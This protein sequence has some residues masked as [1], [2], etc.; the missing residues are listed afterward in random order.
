LPDKPANNTGPRIRREQ[1]T[2]TA[3]LGIYCRD[4]HQSDDALCDD[5]AKLL[6]YAHRRLAVCPFGEDKP[7]CNRCQVHCYSAKMRERVKQVMRYTG[8]RMLTRHPVLALFHILDKIKKS[9][10]LADR[11]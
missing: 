8:P 2:I 4:H 6:D 5:C 11:E 1:R 10:K 3:M 7:A 9:P